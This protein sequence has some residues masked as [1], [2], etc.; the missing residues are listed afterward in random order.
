MDTPLS[1]KVTES[2]LITIDLSKY[3]PV[4]KPISFDIAPFLYK[5]LIL[6]EKEFREALQHHDWN[7]YKDIPVAVFCSNDALIPAWAYMLIAV[8]LDGIAS[9]IYPG[10][11]EEMFKQMFLKEIGQ[12]PTETL[13]GR[14]VVI[15]GCG[16]DP[17]GDFAYLEITKRLL[18]LVKSIMYGEP[19]STVPVFKA[20]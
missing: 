3:V 18:P 11:P 14:R 1:N 17:I 15:K 9:D 2:G 8:K 20:K 16:D 19:C 5:G 4:K 7:Q 10:T 13:S 12:M 6:K